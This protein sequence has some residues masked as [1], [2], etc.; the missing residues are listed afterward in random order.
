MSASQAEHGGSIPLTCSIVESP[1]T[2]G[3][4]MVTGLFLF[5]A[6]HRI[7]KENRPGKPDFLKADKS[8]YKS[9][10]GPPTWCHGSLYMTTSKGLHKISFNLHKNSAAPAH[11]K[12]SK[13]KRLKGKRKGKLRPPNSS[14]LTNLRAFF[15]VPELG[16]VSCHFITASVLWMQSMS[17]ERCQPFR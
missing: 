13:R 3:F 14:A 5:L 2:T 8:K 10:T 6:H 16:T 11:S 17:G 4:S 9:D 12:L 7:C 15:P 1:V